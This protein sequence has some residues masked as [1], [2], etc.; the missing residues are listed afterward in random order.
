[1]TLTHETPSPIAEEQLTVLGARLRAALDGPFAAE[2]AV[3]RATFP[4]D[5]MHLD[6]AAGMEDAREWTLA[7]LIELERRGFG[8]SGVPDGANAVSDPLTAVTTFEMLAHG[9]LS[10][11]IKSGVQFGLFGGAVT[12][13]GTEWHHRTFLP[14]ITDLTLL[15]AF[16][17]TELGHG[18]DVQHLETTLTYV[19]ETDEIEIHSP[20]PSARKA[21]LGNAARHGTMAAVFGQLVVD[22]EQHGIHVVLVPIRDD[23]GVDLPGVT[24][25]DHGHK[26]GLLGVDNGTLQF[27]RV[28]VPRRMLL[29]RYGGVTDEGV[30]SSPISSTSKRFFTMLGTLVRGRVCIGGGAGITARRALSIAVRHGLRRRQFPAAGRPEGVLLLDYLTH[31]RRLLPR[32]AEAYAYGFAQNELVELLVKVQGPA[33]HTEADQRELET[34]AAGL[35]AQTTWFANATVQEARE[36]C[37]GF[38][39]MSENRLTQLRG[40]VDIFATFEGDNTVLMQ[41]VAKALLTGVKESWSALDRSG[42]VQ[43]TTRIF[44]EAMVERT[45]ANVIVERVADGARRRPEETTLVDRG[46]HA[47]MFEERARHSLD[48]LARRMRAASKSGGD[49]FEAFNRLGGHVQFAARAHVQRQ[50]L[51]AFITALEQDLDAQT[52]EVLE[53]L[54]S[55]YALASIHEDRAWFVEHHRMSLGRSKALGDQIDALCRELR[56][57]A[58]PLVEGLGV[59]E[60]WLGTAFLED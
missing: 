38:G 15:G 25:G 35:K 12:N 32:V 33:D 54:C 17:M 31:Q 59:P 57:H 37:G 11:T 23:H 34:R 51:G 26:G 8:H 36:A 14:G 18:S 10:V 5:G 56:P 46:W 13:L 27:D 44:G 7:R 28:R 50:V 16:A 41:L 55:L 3:G 20:T 39:Y 22:G 30:Y 60:A 21:Y 40:D 24:T 42:V 58:L 48:S 1:M 9:D 2:R 45:A 19:R 47:L 43:A 6:P 4:A 53:R 52:R 29:D 49:Q